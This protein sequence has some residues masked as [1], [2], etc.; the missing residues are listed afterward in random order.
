MSPT[1]PRFFSDD[2]VI[3]LPS[4]PNV[5]FIRLTPPRIGD[6]V[7]I[8]ANPLNR[9]FASPSG[10]ADVWDEEMIKQT[11]ERVLA[12]HNRSKT[13]YN[14]LLLLIQIDGKTVGKGNVE[15]LPEVFAGLA[16]IGLDLEESARG[17]GIGKAGWEVLLR[18]SNELDITIAGA[19][20]MSTNKPMRA[21]AKSLGFTEKEE[22]LTVPGRGVVADILFQNIDFRRYKDLDMKVE[23]L[24]PASE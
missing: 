7:N 13:K 15:E 3:T 5:K 22:V 9:P 2:G 16:N 20:T 17:K 19:G 1:D 23:F 18:L 10:L 8:L 14:A 6:Y 21:L 4:F 11:K 12:L 24:G